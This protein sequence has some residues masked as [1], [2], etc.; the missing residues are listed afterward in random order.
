MYKGYEKDIFAFLNKVSNSNGFSEIF[1]VAE[2][3]I[4]YFVNCEILLPLVAM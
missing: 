1:G 2:C 3:E 4:I